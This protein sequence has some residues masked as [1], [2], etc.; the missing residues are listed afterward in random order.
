MVVCHAMKHAGGV[1][2]WKMAGTICDTVEAANVVC[3]HSMVGG[4]SNIAISSGV[5]ELLQ[6]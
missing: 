4:W 5:L 2:A 3:I 1:I 6:W